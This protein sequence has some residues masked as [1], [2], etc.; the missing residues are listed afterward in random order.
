MAHDHASRVSRRLGVTLLTCAPWATTPRAVATMAGRM[1]GMW[2]P[3][4][5]VFAGGML[6]ARWTI[7]FLIRQP[8]EVFTKVSR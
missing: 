5:W 1:R 2:S 6:W 8:S 4:Y 3:C 7:R